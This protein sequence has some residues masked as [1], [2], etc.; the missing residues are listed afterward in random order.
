[1]RQS[2]TGWKTLRMLT[3][4]VIWHEKRTKVVGHDCIWA[5][6]TMRTILATWLVLAQ[7]I[8]NVPFFNLRSWSAHSLIPVEVEDSS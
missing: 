3:I 5:T 8:Y 2:L 7:R 4:R 1:M 6:D